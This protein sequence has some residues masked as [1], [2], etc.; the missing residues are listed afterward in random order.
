MCCAEANRRSNCSAEP[1]WPHSCGKLLDDTAAKTIMWLVSFSGLMLNILIL[2]INKKD[3][4]GRNYTMIISSLSLGDITSCISLLIIAVADATFSG[5]YLDN[6]IFW[7]GSVS[8]FVVSLCAIMANVMSIFSIHMISICRYF[9]VKYPMGT[10]FLHERKV[11]RIIFVGNVTCFV[12]SLALNLIY[13]HLHSPW[14]YPSGLCLL[15]GN[16]DKSLVPRIVSIIT[17]ISQGVPIITIPACLFLLMQAM[18]SQQKER[19]KLTH[20]QQGSKH[21]S[22]TM[23]ASLSNL[24]CWVPSSILLGITLLWEEYPFKIFIWLTVI[25]LPL[26]SLI[27]PCVLVYAKKVKTLIVMKTHLHLPHPVSN[28]SQSH[29]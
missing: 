24:I 10:I 15:V 16:I 2:C 18:I 3:V 14:L 21:M 22:S 25:V 5:K 11:L 27:N 19:A 12:L 13:T 1:T 20:K 29:S 28:S 23:I 6:E 7:R 17:M 9:V 8:C 26:N 4:G